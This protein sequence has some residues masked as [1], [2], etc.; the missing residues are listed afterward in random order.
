M[1]LFESMKQTE[2]HDVFDS[3]NGVK[4]SGEELQAKVPTVSLADD[5]SD[6]QDVV[7]ES[8]TQTL[9]LVIYPGN[10]KKTESMSLMTQNKENQKWFQILMKDL[11]H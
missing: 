1:D 3:L 10:R 11:I 7:L 4:S 6:K 5:L 8:K 2:S 9:P